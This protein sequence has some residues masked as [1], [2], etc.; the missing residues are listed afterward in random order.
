[1][2]PSFLVL[3]LSSYENWA[4]HLTYLFIVVA[5]ISPHI[6]LN[7][8]KQ[9]FQGIIVVSFREGH[10]WE[11]IWQIKNSMLFKALFRASLDLLTSVWIAFAALAS[12]ATCGVRLLFGSGTP[13][14]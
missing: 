4:G 13:V 11:S 9:Y 8:A 1:M 12:K 2:D 6:S 7:H 10:Q 5:V 14:N 3:W